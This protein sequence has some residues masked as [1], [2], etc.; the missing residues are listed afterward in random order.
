MLVAFDVAIYHT[1][2]NTWRGILGTQPP[3]LTRWFRF[4]ILSRSFRKD[5]FLKLWLHLSQKLNTLSS[6]LESWEIKILIPLSYRIKYFN[7]CNLVMIKDS[8]C[9]YR[10]GKLL[11]ANVPSRISIFKC[12]IQIVHCTCTCKSHSSTQLQLLIYALFTV[13]TLVSTCIIYST[14]NKWLLKTLK[15]WV[16]YQ[17]CAIKAKNFFVHTSISQWKGRSPV[18]DLRCNFN[19]DALVN[20]FS[21]PSTGHAWGFSPLW[22]RMWDVK[23]PGAENTLLHPSISHL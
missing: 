9:F 23:V 5:L 10:D 11:L 21:H 12:Q 2:C 8:M 14:C 7:Y 6:P 1:H 22:D 15:T 13:F 20:R 16:W 18:W 17:N 4:D 19:L 3:A